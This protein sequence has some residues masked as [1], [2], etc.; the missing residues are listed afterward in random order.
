[1]ENYDIFISYKRRNYSNYVA[2]FIY[3][4]LVDKGYSVFLDREEMKSGEFNAQIYEHIKKAK[5][6]IVLL[7][8][9]SLESITGERVSDL[10][11][12]NSVDS[13][14][15][16]NIVNSVSSGAKIVADGLSSGINT[17]TDLFLEEKDWFIREIKQAHSC[18]KNIIPI[19][20]NGYKM[21]NKEDLPFNMKWFALT[22]SIDFKPDADFVE[23]Y[24]K[25]FVKKKYLKSLHR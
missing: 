24:D 9:R 7:E 16:G 14:F 23:L 1:M 8:D 13:G 2:P 19:L 10:G 4:F 3:H 17:L 20:L 5:D 21:P 12:N 25:F 15:F 11:D 18:G 22:Q 6:I